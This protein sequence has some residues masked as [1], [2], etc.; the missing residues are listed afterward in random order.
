MGLQLCLIG[1]CFE[2]DKA[3]VEEKFGR[4][5]KRKKERKEGGDYSA[6]S[7]H[8]RFPNRESVHGSKEGST[9]SSSAIEEKHSS[10]STS[11]YSN[12]QGVKSAGA[13]SKP[14]PKIVS[15]RP[16]CESNFSEILK[17]NDEFHH[18]TRGR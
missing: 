7:K 14:R 9:S 15:Y 6:V 13:V 1:V 8:G 17:E 16:V 10:K 2:T 11:R 18:A 3:R 12:Q 4:Q 5:E